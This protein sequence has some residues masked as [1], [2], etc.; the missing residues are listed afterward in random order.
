MNAVLRYQ[1][2]KAA[3]VIPRINEN[4]FKDWSDMSNRLENMGLVERYKK[5]ILI[6]ILDLIHRLE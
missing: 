4:R 6:E 1:L 2:K 5:I 3:K